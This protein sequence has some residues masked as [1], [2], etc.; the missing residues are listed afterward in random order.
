MSVAVI[1]CDVIKET[2]MPAMAIPD[3]SKSVF[4]LFLMRK[5]LPF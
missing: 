1:I 4:L 3:V 2:D 5:S